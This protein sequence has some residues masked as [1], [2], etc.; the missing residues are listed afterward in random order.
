EVD[1]EDAPAPHGRGGDGHED[2]AGAHWKVPFTS[3]PPTPRPTAG[4]TAADGARFGPDSTRTAP[5]ASAAAPTPSATGL[6]TWNVR[7]VAAASS[8]ARVH[9]QSALHSFLYRFAAS[10]VTM[11]ATTPTATATPPTPSATKPRVVVAPS[12]GGADDTEE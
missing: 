4:A 3:R 1:A 5:P 9:A 12:R 10:S 8:P 6:T 7:P 2:A 11:P